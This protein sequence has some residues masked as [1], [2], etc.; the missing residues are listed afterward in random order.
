VYTASDAAA[1]ATEERLFLVTAF[2]SNQLGVEPTP[3]LTPVFRMAGGAASATVAVMTRTD[4][5][6]RAPTIPAAPSLRR[7]RGALVIWG[8]PAAAVGAVT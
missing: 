1:P 7:R 4:E 5:A 2:A 8:P 6:T 3:L